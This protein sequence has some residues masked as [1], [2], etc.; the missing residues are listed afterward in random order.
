MLLFEWDDD[1]AAL[2]VEKHGVSF[3]TASLVFNDPFCI[4]IYDAEHSSYEDR[5]IALGRVGDVLFVVYTLRES[6]TRIISAR[7]A[8]E[9]ERR[10]YYGRF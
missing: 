9:K 1:K 7:L 10:L 4:S 5:F 3:E 8:T 2:N 6:S